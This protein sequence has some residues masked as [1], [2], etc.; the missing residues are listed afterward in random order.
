[1]T[2]QKLASDLY[3]AL[4]TRRRDNG[5][6]FHTLRDD[7]PEWMR[8]AVREAHGDMLPDDWRYGA[9][10]RVACAMADVAEDEDLDDAAHEACDAMVDVYNGTLCTW[11]ASHGA[12]MGYCDE[13]AD[14]YGYDKERGIIGLM[15]LGQFAEYREIWSALASALEAAQ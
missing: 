6:A 10:K 5:E 7:A 11:L 1:M 9:I 15:Q 2:I 8:D 4:E 14:E 13:A 12:R 3:D